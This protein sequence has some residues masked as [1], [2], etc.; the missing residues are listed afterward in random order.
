MT[1]EVIFG[2]PKHARIIHDTTVQCKHCKAMI[3]LDSA[4][5]VNY[6]NSGVLG[7]VCPL[8]GCFSKGG[9]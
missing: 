9:N 4:K 5:C 6:Y 7:I 3:E 8:C 2:V 1:F